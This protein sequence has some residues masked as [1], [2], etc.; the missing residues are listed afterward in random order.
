MGIRAIMVKILI[1]DGNKDNRLSISASLTK[2]IPECVVINA[3]SVANGIK[4]AQSQ[5]P[6]VILLDISIEQIDGFEICRRLKAIG[7]T[8]N[9]P[10]IMFADTETGPNTRAK[11]LDVGVASFLVKPVDKVEL[12]AKINAAVRRKKADE[13]QHKKIKQ[14]K[15]IVKEKAKTLQKRTQDLT[16]RIK[17]LNC[18]YEIAA[19]RELPGISLEEILQGVVDLIPLSLRHPEITCARII[20]GY[21]E[22]R[23]ENFRETPW[24]HA[25][26]II[27]SSDWGGTLEVYYIERPENAED[28]FLEEESNLLNAIGERLGKIAERV[29]TD[30]ALRLES[31]N[32]INIMRSMQD[33]V[34]IAN[35]QYEIEYINPALR[36]EFGPVEG[37]KC[38]E[39][40]RYRKEIC[41]WCR[42]QDVFIGKTVRWE[43]NLSKKKKTYDVLSTPSI[44]ADGSIRMLSIFRDLTALKKAQKE[45]EER[46]LLYR[47]L[48]ES[49][50]DGVVLVQDGKILFVNNA[51][52]DMFGYSE[53]KELAEVEIVQLFD[54]EFRGLFQKVFDPEEQDEDIGTLLWGMCVTKEGKKIWI[55]TNRSVISLKSRPA[56]LATMRNITE[57]VLWEKSIQEDTEYLRRENIK[58]RSSIKER[59]KFGNIIGKS[60]PMQNV[61]ELI[62]KAADSDANVIILGETGTGKELVAR[63]IHEM[64]ARTDKAFVP[65]NCGA[66]PENLVESEFFGH[67]KGAFTGAHIDRTG[68]LHTANEG[69]LFL[70]EVGELGLNIQVKLLRALENGEYTPVGDTQVHRSNFRL[71]SATNRDFSEMVNNGLVR[72]DFYYRISV[73]PITLPPLREKKEDIPLLVE[74]FLHLY[75]KGKKVPTIAGRIMEVLYNHDWPGNVRELQSVIQRYLAVGNFDFLRVDSSADKIMGEIDQDYGKVVPDLR[76]AMKSFEKRFILKALNQY[77][78]H[79]GKAAAVLGIDAKTL[80]TKMKKTGLP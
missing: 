76:S 51:F 44:N 29:K 40:F 60:R 23:T 55:S 16:Q 53:P 54:S 33:W 2:S 11:A 50:A 61:Y 70:D 30:D 5:L 46:E 13:I 21:Q 78:W 26:D 24:K 35:D 42:N 47:S 63:A 41:P 64:S 8:E 59:Y 72:E 77:R 58:L 69:I 74:H 10:V 4:K 48:T 65:V 15:A 19:L 3:Q 80:Y 57:Q 7:R 31:E 25:S 6:D 67:R 75:S 27:V 1:I 62:L 39:Y 43:W 52:V 49:V 66:I 45:I 18:L 73:F 38:Y 56:I 71:I 9:I 37:K 20:M 17:E 14:L 68:Y 32:I 79:R 22:F 28:S 12:T 34:Y 36:R